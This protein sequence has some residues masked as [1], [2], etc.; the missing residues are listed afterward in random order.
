VGWSPAPTHAGE[1]VYA[2]DA[3]RVYE[4][5]VD[6]G[7]NLECY[8]RF[9]T[10]LEHILLAHLLRCVHRTDPTVTGNLNIIVDGPL[11]IFG[12]AASFHR[13][14]M[15]LIHEV[16]TDCLRRKLPGPLVMGVSKTGK[17]VEHALLVEH[18]LARRPRRTLMMPVDDAYRY[19][20]IEP[21]AFQR[22]GNFGDETYYG[23]NFLVRTSQGKVFDACLAYPFPSKAAVTDF[24]T[25]K[26]RIANYGDDLARMVSVIEMMQTDL[27]ENAL[28]AVHLAHK[29]ASIAHSPGGRT[30][31]S[32]VRAVVKQ[33]APQRE[34]V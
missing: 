2:T 12:Q 33:R 22:T 1:R 29:Y 9:M 11:A 24:Q 14:I 31:D 23:Q 8:N 3:L 18:V 7:S 13:G 26:V 34:T 20:M 25:E 17:V 30:L 10:A 28:I 27:Y 5:F 21:A 19:Q 16:K 15:H 32:F 4:P 6:E